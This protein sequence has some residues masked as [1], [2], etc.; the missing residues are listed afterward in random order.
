LRGGDGVRKPLD[1]RGGQMQE[2]AMKS[3][4][5]LLTGIVAL[6]FVGPIN[7]P[8]ATID[9]SDI[10]ESGPSG[11]PNGFI[12]ISPPVVV[13]E[14]D[15]QSGGIGRFILTG[16]YN[17]TNPPPAPPALPTTFQFNM[18]D[19]KDDG[20]I[21]CSDTLSIA[22]IGT[23]IPLANTLVQVEF[24]SGGE[25][26]ATRIPELPNGMMANGLPFPEVVLF[27]MFELTVT[28]NSVDVPGPIV[29][30]GLPGLIFAGGGLLGWWR[31]RRKIA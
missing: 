17:A 15:P 13:S 23:G 12:A 25:T 19:P 24:L 22:F 28:A 27:G 18:L 8:A 20:P 7:A 4:L 26:A 16:I 1:P 5:L 29:G 3:R 14:S 2:D 9:I 31:R 11:I 6:A 21:C 10:D 30:A